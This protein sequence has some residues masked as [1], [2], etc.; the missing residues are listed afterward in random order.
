MPRWR[1]ERRRVG[2]DDRRSGPSDE[3]AR[4]CA[5]ARCRRSFEATGVSIDSRA[6]GKGDLFVAL[7][8]RARDGHDFVADALSRGAAAAVVARDVPGASRQRCSRRRHAW[9]ALDDL[10]RA[11]RTRSPR[12]SPASP[13]PSA[14]PAPRKRCAPCWRPQAPTWPA[15]QATTTMSGVPLSLARLPREAR[16]G[17]FELG[18]NHAGEIAPLS[19]QVA[20]ARR[21]HH[22]RRGRRIIESLRQRGGDRRRQ[23]RDLRR[24]APTAASPCSTR[25]SPFRPPGAAM[26]AS[27]ASARIVGFGGTT[28]AEARLVE[29]RLHAIGSD[30]EPDP[31]Q[32]A[33]VSPRRG[34]RAL[35]A[36]QPRGAGRAEALGADVGA[37][38]AA[39]AERAGSPGRGARRRLAFGSGTI[40]LID[41][42]YNA[43]PASMRAVLAV[44]ART[45]PAPGGRRIAVLGDMLELGE[46]ADAARR[47]GAGGGGERRSDRSSCAARTWRRCGTSSPRRKRARTGRIRRRWRRRGRG[48]VAGGRRGARQGLAGQSN[49]VDRRCRSSRQRG[50]EARL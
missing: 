32:A 9:P 48:G 38:A 47:S 15:R 41:E 20:A 49:E 22:Q 12:A 26:R 4:A 11:G 46:Q 45:E 39:L 30:V 21:R 1:A 25:Q 18:M 37:A 14:R 6:V 3:V 28:A 13:A 42:S 29:C 44:L 10:G 2:A 31:R 33:R 8:A 19:R 43:N 40:E 34:R 36:E 17:V 50:G 23:G 5:G 16:Y 27:S 35:G 7:P 24:H